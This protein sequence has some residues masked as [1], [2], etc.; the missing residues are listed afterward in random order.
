V[1]TGL[2]PSCGYDLRATPGMCPECGT[3]PP[4]AAR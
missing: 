3:T 1:L 4:P 2:C